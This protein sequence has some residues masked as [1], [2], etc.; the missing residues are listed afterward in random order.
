MILLLALTSLKRNADLHP[1]SSSPSCI[2][3][4]PNRMKVLLQPEFTN[5]IHF[6]LSLWCWGIFFS[7]TFASK[8]AERLHRLC[9]VRMLLI[10]L[11]AWAS[12][13]NLFSCLL[14]LK[15]TTGVNDECHS[16]LRK[17][18]LFLEALALFVSTVGGTFIHI[19]KEYWMSG[20]KHSEEEAEPSYCICKQIHL[21]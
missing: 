18:F 1:L 6:T 11:T 5:L 16:R 2:N 7:S 8:E 19:L 3:F 20:S 9:L 4:A 12:G 13:I 14:V 15:A 10:M 17:R 21:K